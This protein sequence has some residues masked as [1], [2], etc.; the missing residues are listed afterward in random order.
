MRLRQGDSIRLP[1]R[2]IGT[3]PVILRLALSSL[4]LALKLAISAALGPSRYC[5]DTLGGVKMVQLL[6]QALLESDERIC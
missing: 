1:I 5:F 6:V 4:I 3:G 2:P